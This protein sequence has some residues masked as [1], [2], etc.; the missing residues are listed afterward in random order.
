MS[1]L[2][3]S[4]SRL[5]K[6]DVYPFHMPGHKR[7][8]S[9][10]MLQAAYQLDITEIEDFD[11]LHRPTGIIGQAQKKAAGLWGARES[12]FLVNGSTGGILAALCSISQGK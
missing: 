10:Y 11:N 9:G 12:F 3:Q 1:N 4:L 5:A 2:F 7:N 6:E 8:M